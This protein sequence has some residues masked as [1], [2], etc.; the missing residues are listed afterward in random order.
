MNERQTKDL[1]DSFTFTI[2]A[3]YFEALAAAQFNFTLW[4][5]QLQIGWLV[6]FLIINYCCAQG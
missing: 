3:I 2:L 5:R 4:G 6:N 1:T